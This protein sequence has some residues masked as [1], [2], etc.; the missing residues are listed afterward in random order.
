[1]EN[2]KKAERKVAVTIKK[3]KTPNF[4][5]CIHILIVYVVIHAY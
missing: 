2:I 5:A 3:F 1:M 4:R